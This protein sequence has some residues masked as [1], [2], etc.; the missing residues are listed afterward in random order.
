MGVACGP[1]SASAR[2]ALTG[3]TFSPRVGCTPRTTGRTPS[4]TR[5][6]PVRAAGLLPTPAP[7]PA[8]VT[9]KTAPAATTVI[10]A[11][12]TPCQD[13]PPPIGVAAS[14]AVDA[15]TATAAS[16]APS[17]AAATALAAI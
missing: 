16:P 14:T 11:P 2:V 15:A 8:P 6:R 4:R 10:T 1:S 3:S 5:Y 7:T 13:R 9:A 17:A 12:G